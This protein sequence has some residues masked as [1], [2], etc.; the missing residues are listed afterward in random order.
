MGFI[1]IVYCVFG[2][3][4]MI[5]RQIERGLEGSTEGSKQDKQPNPLSHVAESQ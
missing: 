2:V 5:Y 4:S 3:P 1:K